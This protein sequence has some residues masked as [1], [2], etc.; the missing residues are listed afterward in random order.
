VVVVICQ[1]SDKE[2]I[3]VH[4]GESEH[5]FVAQAAIIIEEVINI[6]L[7]LILISLNTLT[8]IIVIEWA[9]IV[10]IVTIV[11]GI[12]VKMVRVEVVIV[13]E[14]ARHMFLR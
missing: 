6:I 8:E 5:S 14:I 9:F 12:I 2:S 11:G 1:T 13:I 3:T 10:I 4:F 7:I